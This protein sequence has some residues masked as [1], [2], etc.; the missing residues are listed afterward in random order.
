MIEIAP[1][2][3]GYFDQIIFNANKTALKSLFCFS[4]VPTVLSSYNL[5]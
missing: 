1:G 3:W 5:S 2:K 4:Q